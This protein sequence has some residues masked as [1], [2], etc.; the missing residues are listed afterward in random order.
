MFIGALFIIALKGKQPRYINCGIF[1]QWN[2]IYQGRGTNSVIDE[3]GI[4]ESCKT[5][6]EEAASHKRVILYAS[7]DVKF[8]NTQNDSMV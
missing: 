8:R 3:L 1:L 4:D 7:I 2:I 6:F 5:I